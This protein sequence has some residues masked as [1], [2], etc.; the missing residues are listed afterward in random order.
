MLDTIQKTLDT[1]LEDD[2]TSGTYREL[3]PYMP[4]A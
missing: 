1:A 2:P 3:S 4:K